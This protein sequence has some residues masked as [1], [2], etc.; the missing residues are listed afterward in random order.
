MQASSIGIIGG[1]DGP[2][3]VFVAGKLAPIIAVGLGAAA[4]IAL[5]V[6]L[7]LKHR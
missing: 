2:T 4:L 5:G 1:A 3:A 6:W 7:Y